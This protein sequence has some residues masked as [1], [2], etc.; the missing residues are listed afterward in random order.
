[1]L[2]V[3]PLFISYWFFQ[4]HSNKFSVVRHQFASEINGIQ[5]QWQCTKITESG[6]PTYQRD[7]PLLWM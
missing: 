5:R 4:V 2:S 6:S 3:I 7:N 1:M